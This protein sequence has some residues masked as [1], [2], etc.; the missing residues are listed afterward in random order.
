MKGQM[1]RERR[2]FNLHDELS[3]SPIGSMKQARRCSEQGYFQ[4]LIINLFLFLLLKREVSR[5]RMLAKVHAKGGK[6]ACFSRKACFWPILAFGHFLE[7]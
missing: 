7:F 5:F 1:Q 3:S 4:Y 2:G 6:S